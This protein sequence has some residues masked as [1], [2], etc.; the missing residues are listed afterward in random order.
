MIPIST[1]KQFA[2]TR[3]DEARILRDAKKYNGAMYLCGYA[4]EVA[5]KWGI[6][7]R[8]K[9]PYFP[10]SGKDLEASKPKATDREI[11]SADS[12]KVLCGALFTHDLL[13]L[14]W[15]S[16]SRYKLYRTSKSES[17]WNLIRTNWDV[18]L[19]YQIRTTKARETADNMIEAASELLHILRVLP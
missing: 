5:L 19:R 3:L 17:A 7:T 12:M 18:N 14:A 13:A 2:R 15:L 6:C 8:L 4:V 16:G 11:K 10:E 1:L 9:W